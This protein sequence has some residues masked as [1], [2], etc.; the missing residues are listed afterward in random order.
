MGAR[1]RQRSGVEEPPAHRPGQRH[2][3]RETERPVNRDAPVQRDEGLALARSTDM[4]EEPVLLDID[5]LIESIVEDEREA[6]NLAT[7]DVAAGRDW[8]CRPQ[9]LR[10]CVQNLVD[11]AINY[12]GEVSLEDVRANMAARSATSI[13]STTRTVAQPATRTTE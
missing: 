8:I 1:D 3:V 12:G 5:S 11:N 13:L 10:R 7:F 9:M 2:E 6:G 4:R